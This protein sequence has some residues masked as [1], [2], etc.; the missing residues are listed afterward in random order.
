MN[1]G[2]TM[3]CIRQFWNIKFEY[4]LDRSEKLAHAVGNQIGLTM[5]KETVIV[6]EICVQASGKNNAEK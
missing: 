6:Q 3:I 2:K 4:L 5:W 1:V